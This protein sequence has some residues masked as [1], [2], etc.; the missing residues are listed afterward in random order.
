M[1][2]HGTPTEPELVLPNRRYWLHLDGTAFEVADHLKAA[3]YA[4]AES[5]EYDRAIPWG[6]EDMFRHG[7]VR[8]HIEPERFWADGGHGHIATPEQQRWIERARARLSA[9]AGTNVHV[10][11]AVQDQA[12]VMT[13]AHERTSLTRRFLR[14][15]GFSRK[16]PG[17]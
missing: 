9:K 10:A 15:L 16:E 12:N 2:S 14:K 1:E 7:W 11:G 4:Q 17:K 8:I 6:Y 13:S 3:H 5:S